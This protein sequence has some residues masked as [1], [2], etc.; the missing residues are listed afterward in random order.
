MVAALLASQA[1]QAVENGVTDVQMQTWRSATFGMFVHWGAYAYLAGAWEGE[2]V[3][4][5]SEHIMRS[6]EIPLD[7]YREQ[8]VAKFQP[9]KLPFD[10]AGFQLH[11]HLDPSNRRLL[12]DIDPFEV[13][14]GI[15]SGQTARLNATYGDLLHKLLVVGV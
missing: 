15:G 1:A 10:F 11:F 14:V 7:E 6:M 12:R 8:V 9:P 3:S 2:S 5:Y 13:K 4:G